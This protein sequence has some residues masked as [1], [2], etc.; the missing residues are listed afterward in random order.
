MWAQ[1]L[2][3]QE[4]QESKT[5]GKHEKSQKHREVNGEGVNMGAFYQRS[6]FPLI[7]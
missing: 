3:Y 5:H 2:D 7:P 6:A 1:E 4:I